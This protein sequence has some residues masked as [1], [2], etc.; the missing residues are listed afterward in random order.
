M[1]LHAFTL[2]AHSYEL[3]VWSNNTC[4]RRLNF[5]FYD[6]EKVSSLNMHS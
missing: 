2:A 6:E 5:F 4:M 1:Q 3:L